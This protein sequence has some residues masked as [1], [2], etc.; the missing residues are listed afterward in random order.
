MVDHNTDFLVALYDCVDGRLDVMTGIDRV[1]QRAE[2]SQTRARRAAK[3]L[4]SRGLVAVAPET[5]GKL[6][7]LTALGAVEVEEMKAESDAAAVLT[8]AEHQ[9][10]KLFL[11]EWRQ[12][13]H[14][15]EI[16]LEG[17]AFAEAEAEVATLKAQ[18]RSP[19]PK[20]ASVR[21]SA[22]VIGGLLRGA[23]GSAVW[24]SVQSLIRT[25]R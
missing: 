15:N 25:L 1:G 2:M 20:R 3:R 19:K 17:D 11:A 8:S 23:K 14:K 13:T 5:S 18:L 24:T 6:L 7:T 16:P 9:A 12:A 10:V 21:V 4:V 22:R